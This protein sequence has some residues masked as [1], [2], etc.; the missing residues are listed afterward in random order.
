MKTLTRSSCFI[1]KSNWDFHGFSSSYLDD[2]RFY[3]RSL[4]QIEIQ[5][6]M[7]QVCKNVLK[8]ITLSLFLIKLIKNPGNNKWR[9]I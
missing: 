1:G 4:T 2:L 3:N 9:C 7:N 8:F 5:Q 6:L